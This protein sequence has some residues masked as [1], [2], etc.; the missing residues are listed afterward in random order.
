MQYVI[1]ITAGGQ[2]NKMVSMAAVSAMMYLGSQ[3][4]ADLHVKICSRND[5]GYSKS[6]PHHIT[7]PGRYAG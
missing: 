6:P 7:I 4:N 5:R 3:E 2:V 1:L